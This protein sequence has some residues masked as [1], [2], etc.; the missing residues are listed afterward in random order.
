MTTWYRFRALGADD[1]TVLEQREVSVWNMTE[2]Q[3]GHIVAQ[4][5]SNHAMHCPIVQVNAFEKERDHEPR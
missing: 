4:M 1:E 5:L 2:A 3:L